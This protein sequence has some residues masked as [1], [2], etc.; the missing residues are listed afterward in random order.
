MAGERRLRRALE[1]LRREIHLYERMLEKRLSHGR[2][3]EEQLQEMLEEIIRL[4][5]AQRFFKTQVAAAPTRRQ[6]LALSMAAFQ[7]HLGPR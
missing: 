2:L 1:G 6:R 3:K 7:N 4:E 5:D